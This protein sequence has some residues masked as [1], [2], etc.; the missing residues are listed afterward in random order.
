MNQ[1][2]GARK[3]Q[4]PITAAEWLKPGWIF[5][6]RTPG[7]MHLRQ[8]GSSREHADQFTK[9]MAAN[10]EG[11]WAQEDVTAIFVAGEDAA[12]LSEYFPEEFKRN[13]QNK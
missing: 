6:L 13:N 10:F 12:L 11:L 3:K 9:E 2:S 4:I 7:G 8:L 1:E 5:A